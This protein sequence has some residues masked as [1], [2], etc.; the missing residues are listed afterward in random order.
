MDRRRYA[1][2]RS[3]GQ[4]TG[5]QSRWAGVGPNPDRIEEL[6]TLVGHP[7]GTIRD[8]TRDTSELAVDS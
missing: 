6:E 1:E 5:R 8:R 3:G 4:R 7:R 2:L